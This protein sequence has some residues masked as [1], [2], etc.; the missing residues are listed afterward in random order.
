MIEHPHYPG[1]FYDP[2]IVYI[3]T[4][5]PVKD[6]AHKLMVAEATYCIPQTVIIGGCDDE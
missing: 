5:D 3:H 6:A 4:G 2:S 1:T